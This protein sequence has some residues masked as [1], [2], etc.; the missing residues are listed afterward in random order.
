MRS[1]SPLKDT[2]LRVPG[3][4]LDEQVHTAISEGAAPVI[5]GAVF[6]VAIAMLKW[7]RWF[8]PFT[9]PFAMTLAAA[10]FVAWACWRVWRIRRTVTRLRLG[11]DG[12]R[13]VAQVLDELRALG[14]RVFHDV[15]R[16][17]F[18]IDHLLVG[19]KGVFVIETKTHSKL[20]G[21]NA[22]VQYDGREVTIDGVKPDRDPVRQAEASAR[23]LA[24]LLKQLLGRQCFVRPVVLYPGWTWTTLVAGVAARR[25]SGC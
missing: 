12:E 3:Q 15:V 11:R 14:Y 23:W 9:N 8:Y 5:A 6:A 17:S 21:R 25:P 24:E 16:P 4:S 20:V 13:A 18:N 1:R 7:L 19:P 22:R 2:P 10:P